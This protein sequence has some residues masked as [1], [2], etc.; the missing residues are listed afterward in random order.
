MDSLENLDFRLLEGSLVLL[1]KHLEVLDLLMFN[2]FLRQ[3]YISN[4]LEPH[5]LSV[6]TLT[7]LWMDSFPGPRSSSST[8]TLCMRSG[9]EFKCLFTLGCKSRTCTCCHWSRGKHSQLCFQPGCPSLCT[10]CARSTSCSPQPNTLSVISI[11][12]LFTKSVD[13]HFARL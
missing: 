12:C 2:W 4:H 1:A 6:L 5:R 3:N 8:W 7:P 10:G 11:Q 13:T 9:G